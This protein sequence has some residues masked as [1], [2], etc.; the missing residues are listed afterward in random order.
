M[1]VSSRL[2]TLGELWTVLGTQDLY[3]LIEI[4]QVD[5]YNARILAKRQERG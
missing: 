3:D 4:I 1:V 5:A 2:A